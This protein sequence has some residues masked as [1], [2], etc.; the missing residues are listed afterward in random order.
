MQE[1]GTSIHSAPWYCLPVE[2]PETRGSEDHH[3]SQWLVARET[4]LRVM[5]VED[6]DAVCGVWRHM[7]DKIEGLLLCGEY[8]HVMAALVGI[9]KNQPDVVLLDIQLRGEC[10]A[11]VLQ[12]AMER[13]AHTKVIVVS[14]Y[15]DDIYRRHY[16]NAGAYAFFDKSYELKALRRTLE[17]LAM[18]RLNRGDSYAD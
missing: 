17:Q 2:K 1:L 4:M 8:G 10:G 9:A 14:N 11:P 6:S 3:L 16:I 15:A 5:V 12:L 18:A 13:Y 7:I